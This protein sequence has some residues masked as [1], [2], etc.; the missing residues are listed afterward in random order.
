MIPYKVLF[1]NSASAVRLW[2][3]R[4][5]SPDAFV[6]LERGTDS[7]VDSC[8]SFEHSLVVSSPMVEMA[9]SL[10]S[11]LFSQRQA[12]FAPLMQCHIPE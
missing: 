2:L 1:S 6:L 4:E 3:K 11:T 9:S 10:D 12:P 8:C 5:D 7:V